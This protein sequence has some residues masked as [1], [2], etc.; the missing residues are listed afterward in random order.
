MAEIETKPEQKTEA[1]SNN[2]NNLSGDDFLKTRKAIN[3]NGDSNTNIAGSTPN[4]TANKELP[5][6]QNQRAMMERDVFPIHF[7]QEL[8]K[9]VKEAQQH[10]FE[11][12]KYTQQFTLDSGANRERLYRLTMSHRKE[13]AHIF[14]NFKFNHRKLND[15]YHALGTKALDHEVHIVDT[16]LRHLK[17]LNRV[18]FTLEATLE[19]QRSELAQITGLEASSF[20]DKPLQDFIDKKKN[21]TFETNEELLRNYALRENQN[22]N[23][24]NLITLKPE[25]ADK[26]DDRSTTFKKRHF[27][28]KNPGIHGWGI[29]VRYSSNSKGKVDHVF[30]AECSPSSMYQTDYSKA[31]ELINAIRAIGGTW[32]ISGATPQI[33]EYIYLRLARGRPSVNVTCD[34]YHPPLSVRESIDNQNTRIQNKLSYYLQKFSEDI[35][36]NLVRPK[37]KLTTAEGAD[38]HQQA[39][40]D[41]PDA[42]M[43][44]P[45]QTNAQRNPEGAASITIEPPDE[46]TSEDNMGAVIALDTPGR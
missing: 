38:C 1:L 5:Q 25:D 12:A 26:T 35:K 39:Y 3:I 9:K 46:V 8:L 42:L 32:T 23:K 2:N 19:Q 4:Q 10:W 13:I 41:E 11:P 40:P 22:R 27:A 21:Q 16:S 24:T 18:L 15:E 36:K 37:I 44:F 6:G 31:D 17:E 14:N 28:I 33:Q 43:E 20:N 29:H 7:Q 30:V 34:Q 45:Q